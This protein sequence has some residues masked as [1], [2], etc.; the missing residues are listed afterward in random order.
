[1]IPR[2]A[3]ILKLCFFAFVDAY[4]LFIDFVLVFATPC[5]TARYAERA[6]RVLAHLSR[7]LDRRN[8]PNFPLVNLPEIVIFA[9]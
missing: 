7:R 6:L 5:G 2:N 4:S 9:D 8:I 1:M 3:T